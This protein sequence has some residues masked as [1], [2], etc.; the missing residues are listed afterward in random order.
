MSLTEAVVLLE[1]EL[2]VE[3]LKVVTSYKAS[4][5]FE[6]GLEKMG[7]ISYEFG[8]RAVLERFPGRHP[9]AAIEENPFAESLIYSTRSKFSLSLAYD[10]S[11]VKSLTLMV[12]NITSGGVAFIHV[13][14]RLAVPSS[15]MLT[16]S[17]VRYLMLRASADGQSYYG[18]ACCTRHLLRCRLTLNDHEVVAE[19]APTLGDAGGSYYFCGISIIVVQG[20]P[21]L[22]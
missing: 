19:P 16:T 9:K 21:Y 4:Q 22:R 10:A 14:R 11:G 2:K 7:R 15:L 5:G 13:W 6:S 12:E 1:T 3:D 18:W 8:Y 17:I 20:W